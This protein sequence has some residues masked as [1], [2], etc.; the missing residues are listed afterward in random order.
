MAIKI[1]EK[2]AP[3][4]NPADGD[5]PY[6]SI[7]NES[8][9]G[10]KDGTPLEAEWGNDYAGADA[11]LF[12]QAGIVPS[13]QPDKLGASQRVDA[14]KQLEKAASNVTNVG[15]GSVQDFIDDVLSGGDK[16]IP[17]WAGGTVYSDY[18]PAIYRRSTNFGTS[19]SI[20]SKYDA[21]FNS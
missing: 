8:V 11:E 12:A 14:I 3:R 18:S 1:Y 19:S 21:V 17:S 13:G 16:F 4:A 6:G 9:P 7:K 5:Y 2:F 20:Y 10:A 15:G